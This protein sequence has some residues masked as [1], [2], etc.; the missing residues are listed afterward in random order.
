MWVMLN[1]TL[2]WGI[3][4]DSSTVSQKEIIINDTEWAVASLTIPNWWNLTDG[5]ISSD[6]I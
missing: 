4:P 2:E 5:N 6:E 1:F 3:L